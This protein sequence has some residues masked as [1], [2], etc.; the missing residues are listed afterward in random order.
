MLPTTTK[1]RSLRHR[2]GSSRALRR[3]AGAVEEGPVVRERVR[4]KEPTRVYRGRAAVQ[5]D[6]VRG[7]LR[8]RLNLKLRDSADSGTKGDCLVVLGSQ[9]GASR[10]GIDC[11][12]R[13]LT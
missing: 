6:Y 10:F 13:L 1:L 2:C 8:C 11:A 3:A 12:M 4:A 7:R 5:L 9:G